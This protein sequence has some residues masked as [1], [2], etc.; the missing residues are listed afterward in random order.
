M[1]AYDTYNRG[2]LE[3]L[4]QEQFY[5]ANVDYKN[6]SLSYS[7]H[8]RD[9]FPLT[10]SSWRS[11]NYQLYVQGSV[12]YARTFGKHNVTGMVTAYRKYWETTDPEI[13]YN[14]IGTAAR[15]T[16]S[17]D[18]RYLVE[19]NLGYNGSEQFAPSKRFG[20]FPSASLGWIASNESFLKDNE[21]ITWLKFRGSYG[22]VGNDFMGGLRFLFQDNIEVGG[23]TNVSGLGGHTISEGLLGNKSIT[24]ELSKKMNFGVELGLFKD[25][26]INFDYFTENRDQILIS[27]Q[28]IPSFQGVSSS[29][30]PKVNMGVVK[31]HGYEI[32]ASYSHS[33]N[34]DFSLSVKGNFGF[35]DNE[36][37][38]LDEPMR[39]EEYAYQYRTEGFRL[40][41]AWG[42]LIDWNSPGKG[43]FTS[44]EEI[45]N[46]YD[47]GFGGKP[48]VGDFVY[49]DVNGDG[50]IDDKD[51]SP[52]GYST[53]SL[54]STTAVLS[55]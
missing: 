47:Y 6:D 14:V 39:S 24:W 15:A 18:D 28:T 46:Y 44:Q 37:V 2:I 5:Y 31:N 30:I 48:R 51:L 36:V 41:Q 54:A 33:F 29:Y 21:Y 11:S 1:A 32:E 26:R 35:N 23:G 7:L 9:T 50:V 45:D 43:Y 22:L 34:K 42:Y 27:R 40:G 52:I 25:F 10:M 16:Y 12:N 3:G 53:R 19:A 38:E 13:P 4:E 49:K 20:L 8:E 17:F 55:V